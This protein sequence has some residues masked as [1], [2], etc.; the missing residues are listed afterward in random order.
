MSDFRLRLWTEAYSLIYVSVLSLT[1]AY[2]YIWVCLEI[3]QKNSNIWLYKKNS[4]IWVRLERLFFFLF[5]SKHIISKAFFS[6]V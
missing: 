5:K 6:L 4:N 2:S 3:I 1:K